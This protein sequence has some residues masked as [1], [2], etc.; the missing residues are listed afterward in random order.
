MAIDECE[1]ERWIREHESILKER[2]ADRIEL[3]KEAVQDEDAW[4]AQVC[5]IDI[6][7]YLELLSLLEELRLWLLESK[8]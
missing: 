7:A 5:C 8:K 1:L 4:I 6:I 3:L 2:V